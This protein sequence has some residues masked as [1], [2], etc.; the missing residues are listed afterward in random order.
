MIALD[1]EAL[2]S[3]CLTYLFEVSALRMLSVYFALMT[4]RF[5]YCENVNLGSKVILYNI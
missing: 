4:M 5:I 2:N 3:F 1:V